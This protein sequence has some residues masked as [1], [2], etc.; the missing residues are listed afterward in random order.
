MDN[1]VGKCK[2]KYVTRSKS[3]WQPRNAALSQQHGQTTPANSQ[4][5]QGTSSCS[6]GS[7]GCYSLLVTTSSPKT[8]IR[9]TLSQG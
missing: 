7:C 2:T 5:Q 8:A 9:A 4:Q 3:S 1:N 6:S